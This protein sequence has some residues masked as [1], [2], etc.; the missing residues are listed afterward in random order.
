MTIEVVTSDRRPSISGTGA[1]INSLGRPPASSMTIPLAWTTSLAGRT[2]ASRN[3]LRQPAQRTW[4]S[5]TCRRRLAIS[6]SDIP[7]S[8]CFLGQS[9]RHAGGCSSITRR[10]WRRAGDRRPPHRPSATSAP[11]RC[12]RIYPSPYPR[13][14]RTGAGCEP[15]RRTGRRSAGEPDAATGAVERGRG[16]GTQ[17]RPSG[18]FRRPPRPS[19]GSRVW[20]SAVSPD[21]W[22]PRGE[23]PKTPARP[24]LRENAP[25]GAFVLAET[26]PTK[27]HPGRGPGAPPPPHQPPSGPAASDAAARAAH[28]REDEGGR[29]GRSRRRLTRSG[30]AWS[31]RTRGAPAPPRRSDGRWRSSRWSRS[32]ARRPGRCSS[33]A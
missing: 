23:G 9:T 4:R 3:A 19:G 16:R 7:A 27:F 24:A 17:A 8:T 13:P 32:G 2:A 21:W 12:P 18:G 26:V 25:R 1:P 20:P 5:R 31:A 10:P 14:L 29:G 6:Q 22:G 33:R 11:R 30:R 28:P 15:S